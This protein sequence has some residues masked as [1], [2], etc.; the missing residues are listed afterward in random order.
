MGEISKIETSSLSFRLQ[1]KTL[2]KT[3]SSGGRG[4]SV[5]GGLQG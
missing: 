5:M 4:Q 3:K 2:A 1:L